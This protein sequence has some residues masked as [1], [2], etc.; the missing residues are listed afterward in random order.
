MSTLVFRNAK[1]LIDGAEL[2]ASFTDGPSVEISVEMLDETAHGDDSRVNKGGLGTVTISGSGNCEFGSG[3]VADILWNRVGVDGTVLAIFAD[4]IEEGTT[5]EK[6]FA[7][8]G[9]LEDFTV[10][11]SVGALLPFSFTAQSRG[12]IP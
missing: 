10:G 8:L 12:V 3:N 7:L 9:V 4:G 6:G 5:S 2:A 1:I 11:G